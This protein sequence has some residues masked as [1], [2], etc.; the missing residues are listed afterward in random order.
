M[1]SCLLIVDRRLDTD[2]FAT[3]Q[4]EIDN[5]QLSDALALAANENAVH[6]VCCLAS[7]NQRRVG[8]MPSRMVGIVSRGS[9]FALVALSARSAMQHDL[10]R[11]GHPVFINIE[12]R[13]F[14]SRC[15][16]LRYEP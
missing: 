14:R 6:P 16:R 8:S 15:R 10:M 1:D 12:F 5:Q 4:S 9:A 3:Q 7:V 11:A 13:C 2:C